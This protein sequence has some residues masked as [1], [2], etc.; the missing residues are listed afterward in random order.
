VPSRHAD[1]H[2]APP[3]F[4][5]VEW[6]PARPGTR[7]AAARTRTNA[8][9]KPKLLPCARIA[10]P[11]SLV[12]RCCFC[13]RKRW[14]GPKAITPAACSSPPVEGVAGKAGDA[15]YRF[16]R[17]GLAGRGSVRCASTRQGVAARRTSPK[18]S[19]WL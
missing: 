11:P 7:E 6:R 19:Y 8:S 1:A 13:R 4:A 12:G 14:R 2:E 5:E 16:V 10:S 3:A 18:G 17:F 9:T 15:R